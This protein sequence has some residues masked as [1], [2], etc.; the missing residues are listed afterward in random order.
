MLNLDPHEQ[1]TTC[2]CLP[3]HLCGYSKVKLDAEFVAVLEVIGLKG[4]FL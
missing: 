1:Q 2:T 3:T 4:C